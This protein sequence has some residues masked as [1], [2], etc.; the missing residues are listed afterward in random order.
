MNIVLFQPCGGETEPYCHGALLHLLL[1]MTRKKWS[2]SRWVSVRLHHFCVKSSDNI[3]MLCPPWHSLIL[4]RSFTL[5]VSPAG[6]VTTLRISD[7]SRPCHSRPMFQSLR[8]SLS[9]FDWYSQWQ[10]RRFRIIDR[11]WSHRF[12]GLVC[13]AGIIELWNWVSELPQEARIGSSV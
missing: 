13:A 9:M 8:L 3:L 5:H 12:G 1:V 4:C 11:F 10:Y 7:T 2:R 6:H